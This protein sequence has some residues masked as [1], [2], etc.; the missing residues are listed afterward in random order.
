MAAEDAAEVPEDA[1]TRVTCAAAAPVQ[2]SSNDGT[3]LAARMVRPGA[4]Y[5]VHLAPVALALDAS[6]RSAAVARSRRSAVGFP[7]ARIAPVAVYREQGAAVVVVLP[8]WSPL[9]EL[10]HKGDHGN[11]RLMSSRVEMPGVAGSIG[12]RR[13]T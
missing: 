5:R 3:R 13:A 4:V 6:C 2:R 9:W 10:R 7:V 1:A 12:A 8:I 11:S